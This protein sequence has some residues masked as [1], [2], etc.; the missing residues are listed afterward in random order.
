MISRIWLKSCWTL[1]LAVGILFAPADASLS[2]I[3][4]LELGTSSALAQEKKPQ[5]LMELL[6]QRRAKQAKPAAKPKSAA[7]RRATTQAKK[8]KRVTKRAPKPQR[9]AVRRQV[10]A[11]SE[12][13][14][15]E[16][17][18]SENAR[19]VLV[20]GD[21][22]A[23]GISQ[24]LETAFTDVAN[25]RIETR[26]NGS[27]GFVRDDFYD[28]QSEIGA[29]IEEVKPD[30]VVVQLGSNDRQ[31]LR[32]DGKT[33]QVRT[34][35]WT[36]E[37]RRRVE[38]FVSTIRS[39][40][41]LTVWVG[42]PPYKF[43]SMSADM[44]AFNEIYRT[45]VEAKQG[46]FVDIW[47][48]FVTEAGGFSQSGSDIKGQT[49]RLRASDGINFTKA[50]KRKMAFYAERQL[51]LLLGDDASPLLTSLA[52]D[53]LPILK[54]PPLQTESELERTNP[55]AMIDPDFDGGGVLLGDM[56]DRVNGAVE[57]QANPL[58]VR[59]VRQRLVE[60]GSAPPTQPGRAGNFRW[61]DPAD[62]TT[63]STA[64]QP[65]G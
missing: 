56:T 33:E 24:G 10:A 58:Q 20:V 43:A 65:A 15:T 42:A 62:E 9:P 31:V 45:A 34:E 49:V 53:S 5:T 55:I 52:P 14:V 47:D 60:D 50:G 38:A 4:L 25:V 54:L 41:T 28:W 6:R 21:F 51:K 37:Y 3:K 11:P 2:P 23:D 8:T 12:P 30:I 40:N 29:I 32:I 64:T 63:S 13:V 35:A 36:N 26:T 19:R 61:V 7:P 27:S 18:K 48:G 17:E 46:Y 22:V 16:V 44:L 1:L 39:T 57:P 59:S